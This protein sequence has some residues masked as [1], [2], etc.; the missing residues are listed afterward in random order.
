MTGA[1]A[2]CRRDSSATAA[3]DHPIRPTGRNDPDASFHGGRHDAAVGTRV[4]AGGEPLT[5]LTGDGCPP[6][7][8]GEH[9]H[10]AGNLPGSARA[11]TWRAP[12]RPGASA[13][14]PTR[15][16]RRGAGPA[17]ATAGTA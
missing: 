16:A 4:S 9:G 12:A 5:V 14:P 6:W 2:G 1:P 10:P 17:G 13:T 8:R 11:T 3:L 15:D 7:C